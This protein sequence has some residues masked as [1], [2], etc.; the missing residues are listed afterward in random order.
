V[1]TAGGSAPEVAGKPFAPAAAMVH[2][3]LGAT[4]VMVGDRPTTDGDFA[5][6]LGWPFALVL[7]GVCVPVP[8]PGEEPVPDPAPPYLADDLAALVPRLVADLGP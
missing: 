4:G 5:A 8:G 6:R 1:A 2:H 7:S 3:R